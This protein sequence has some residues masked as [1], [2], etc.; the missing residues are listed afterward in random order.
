MKSFLLPSALALALSS[1]ACGPA[2]TNSEPVWPD[3]AKKWFDRAEASYRTGDIDDAELS[4]GNALRVLPDEPLVRVLGARIALAKL[5]Y[6]RS[7]QLLATVESADASAIRGRAYWYSGQIDKAA[8]ELEK[9][10][11][12]PEVRDI[13]ATEVAKLAR[14]GSGRKPFKMSGGLLAMMEMPQVAST[15]LVVPVEVNGEPALGL[16]A[17]GTAE[18]VVDSGGPGGDPKWISLR[19]GERIEVKDVP[20]LSKDLSGISK[21]LNAPIKVLIGVNLLRH[22]HPTIDF[23]GSQFVVRSFEPPPPPQATTVRIS[24]VRGGGMMMRGGFGTDLNAPPA[25]LLIDTSMTFPLA[26]DEGGWKKA[27]LPTSSLRSIP[28]AGG[29]RA[30]ILPQLRL[31]AFTIPQVPGVLGAPVAELEKG[32]GVDLDGLVGSGLLATFRVTLADRGRTMW[33]EDLPAEAL[34][35]APKMPSL[36]DVGDVPDDPEPEP[37]PT[38]PAAKAGWKAPKPKGAAAPKAPAA[39]TPPAPKAPAPGAKP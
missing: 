36:P 35:P 7:T 11:A 24:Y 20:A 32:L 21:Q 34:I 9:L 6:D 27:G 18:A 25:S 2:V 1:M 23:S 31:G 3:A 10:V 14:R 39:N 13:W 15:S 8:D 19:F 16:I 4:L 37:E 33:L 12:D 38:K 29:L 22:L 26:L 30:G 5:E 28:N 17:T